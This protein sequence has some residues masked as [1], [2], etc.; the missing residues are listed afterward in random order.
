MVV[1]VG[2]EMSF[3]FLYWQLF[4]STK[5]SLGCCWNHCS[6]A[7]FASCQ[8]SIFD[9]LTQGAQILG[10][11]L[12]HV[13]EFYIVW[14]LYL[15]KFV[16]HYFS[17]LVFEDANITFNTHNHL[18]VMYR[19]QDNTFWDNHDGYHV[20]WQLYPCPEQCPSC[21]GR[22]WTILHKAWTFHYVTSMCSAPLGKC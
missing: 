20:A 16:D 3:P 10:A 9:T 18:R 1:P 12:P 14:C 22:C 8:N 5:S 19:H 11:R 13:N 21:A 6:T 2:T 7:A 4:P 15:E 17:T